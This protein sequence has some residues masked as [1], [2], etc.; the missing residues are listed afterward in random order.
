[1]IPEYFNGTLPVTNK[2]Q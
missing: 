1:L 2:C